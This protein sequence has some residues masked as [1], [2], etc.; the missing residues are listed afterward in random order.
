M[1]ASVGS[2]IIKLQHVQYARAYGYADTGVGSNLIKLQH[3]QYAR[4]NGYA[5]TARMQRH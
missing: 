5:D 2:N 4:A 1:N 3:V